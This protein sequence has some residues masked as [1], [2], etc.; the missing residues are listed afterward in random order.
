M[1]VKCVP[2][3]HMVWTLLETFVNMQLSRM[4]ELDADAAL[5]AFGA[6]ALN[7]PNQSPGELTFGEQS[8]ETSGT[9]LM[10]ADFYNNL[11]W[12][13]ETVLYGHLATEYPEPSSWPRYCIDNVLLCGIASHEQVLH[14]LFHLRHGRDGVEPYKGPFDKQWDAS[15]VRV[16]IRN[17]SEANDLVSC[18]AAE[19]VDEADEFK[20][21]DFITE[22]SEVIAFQLIREPK[23]SRE[24]H[25][26]S[27]P[28]S[29]FLDQFMIE[30]TALTSERRKVRKEALQEMDSLQSTRMALL[31]FK[32][33]LW[34]VLSCLTQIS[35]QCCRVEILWQT[36]V[37]LCSISRTSQN[38][39]TMRFVGL[40]WLK[41]Q[42]NCAK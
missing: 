26:F 24:R 14:R 2:L 9:W 35:I 42:L 31:S 28:T 32:V 1:G 4:N 30:N 6:D 37:Q 34:V 25:K 29:M 41:P 27:Y 16:T 11:A 19:F 10:V 13:V 8:Y 17:S 7:S 33:T 39:T 22:P 12:A 3:A 23:P 15:S 20:Q 36:C 5:Q 38:I 18:L 40:F 21:N